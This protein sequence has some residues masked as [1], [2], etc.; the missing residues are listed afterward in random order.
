MIADIISGWYNDGGENALIR[1]VLL[2]TL[3]HSLHILDDIVFILFG[4]N[5]SGNVLTTIINGLAFQIMIRL[6]YIEE[7][8][9]DLSNFEKDL[10]VWN[11][12]D[13][14]MVIFRKGLNYTMEDARKFFARYG[15]TYTPADK[16]AIRDIMIDFDDMTFLKRKWVKVDDEI[17]APID[18]DVIREI[19]R[20]SESDPTNMTDQLQRYNAA[21]LEASNY[22]RTIFN[23]M[24]R[25][26][27]S[28]FQ[29]LNERGFYLPAKRLFTYER[30]YEIKRDT[31]LNVDQPDDDTDTA[32][33]SLGLTLGE[34]Y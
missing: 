22:G 16:T 28:Q 10:A 34:S 3:S 30:C 12:G 17:M 31:S 27:V 14:N 13:D 23:D 21:L 33:L 18:M 15:M 4:G 19:P 1:K 8:N 24:R 11:Y 9:S 26:F 32:V 7:I 2:K 20:W 6:F 25:E 5:P 29:S